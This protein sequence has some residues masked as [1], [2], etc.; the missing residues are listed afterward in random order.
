VAKNGMLQCDHDDEIDLL[1]SF[2]AN[3]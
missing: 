1:Y 2:Y 3:V